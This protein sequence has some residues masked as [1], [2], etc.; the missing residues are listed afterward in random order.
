MHMCG[1]LFEIVHTVKLEVMSKNKHR[2]F[3]D[4]SE[5]K[6]YFCE[7]WGAPGQSLYRVL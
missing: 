1:N 2:W 3:V 6:R 5:I 4:F 7:W